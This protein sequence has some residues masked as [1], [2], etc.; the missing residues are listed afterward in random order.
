VAFQLHIRQNLD[1]ASNHFG[2]GEVRRFDVGT[3]RIGS[4]AECECRL[5]APG[6]AP[7]HLLLQRTG[8]SP[9]Q[10]RACPQEGAAAYL[11]AQVLAEPT[12]LRSGDELRVEHWTLRFQ[13][14]HTATGLN[15]PFA[16]MSN[17]AKVAVTLILCAEVAVVVWV[18]RR[19]Y[20]VA[21]WET[22]IARHKVAD[23]LDKLSRTNRDSRA[24]GDFERTLRRGINRELQVRTRYVA[25][26]GRQLSAAQNRLLYDELDAFDRILTALAQGTLPPALP[27]LELESGVQA[28]LGNARGQ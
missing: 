17:L 14:I 6:F 4:G 27:G 15:R 1:S 24:A 23:L 13:R 18:P 28:L 19:M 12:T 3:V 16:L 26:H 11:N 7:C 25:E 2:P 5:S 9:D 8:R 10:V 21:A 20:Q 22:D